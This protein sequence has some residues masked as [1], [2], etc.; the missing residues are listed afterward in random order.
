M[1]VLPIHLFFPFFFLLLPADLA[2]PAK[3]LYLHKAV[4]PD[5][6]SFAA[7]DILTVLDQ[8]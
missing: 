6:L 7:G 8:R 3:G 2:R 1:T 4:R 5:L